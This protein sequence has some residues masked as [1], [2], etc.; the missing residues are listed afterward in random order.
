[1]G[2]YPAI[3]LLKQAAG[4]PRMTWLSTDRSTRRSTQTT[5]A[6]AVGRVCRRRKAWVV[7]ILLWQSGLAFK[8]CDASSQAK[9]LVAELAYLLLEVVDPSLEPIYLIELPLN[10]VLKGN[11]RGRR[12]ECFFTQVVFDQRDEGLGAWEIG[13]K[14]SLTREHWPI[15][16][17]K[18]KKVEAI[19]T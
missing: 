17:Q 3:H 14:D 19:L 13:V 18:L 15:L 2:V 4:L 5:G 11:N 7:R 1:L 16:L 10:S 9:V 8:L 6:F 12:C